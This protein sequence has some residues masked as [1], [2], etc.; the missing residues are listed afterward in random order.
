MLKVCETPNEGIICKVFLTEAQIE[1]AKLVVCGQVYGEAVDQFATL[2]EKLQ[3]HGPRLIKLNNPQPDQPCVC[4]FKD[5]EQWYRAKTVRKLAS[6]EW[7]VKFI[8]YG[9]SEKMNTDEL[10]VLP[11][12]LAALPQQALTMFLADWINPVGTA[13]V[14][15][16]VVS[17]LI[18]N[19]LVYTDVTVKVIEVLSPGKVKVKCSEIETV[20]CE[21]GYAKTGLCYPFS[22]FSVGSQFKAYTSHILDDG[23][24]YLQELQSATQLDELMDEMSHY[25]A[26][27]ESKIPLTE[28]NLIPGTI[29]AAVYSQDQGIYRAQILDVDGESST[30][31]YI[32]YGDSE[33]QE[34]VNMFVLPKQFCVLEYQAIA[35]SL[36]EVAIS[37]DLCSPKLKKVLTKCTA[38][39]ILDITVIDHKF[40]S[41]VQFEVKALCDDTNICI[42]LCNEDLAVAKP[43]TI[44]NAVEDSVKLCDPEICLGKPYKMVITH[45]D[46]DG[47]VYLMDVDSTASLDL[48]MNEIA[49]YCSSSDAEDVVYITAGMPCCALYD[50]DMMWYRAKVSKVDGDNITV[51]YVDYGNTAVTTASSLKK[52]QREHA[53][54]PCQAVQGSLSTCMTKDRIETL[55]ELTDEEVEVEFT[56]EQPGNKYA[57]NIVHHEKHLFCDALTDSNTQQDVYKDEM[58]KFKKYDLQVGSP[59]VITVSHALPSVAG[60]DQSSSLENLYSPCVSLGTFVKV[61]VCFIEDP[62]CLWVQQ[63]CNKKKLFTLMYSMN[64][65]YSLFAK[66]QGCLDET[67]T[68]K[69]CCIKLCHVDNVEDW[70]R[71]RILCSYGNTVEIKLIDFGNDIS[72]NRDEVKVLAPQFFEPKA[73]ALR[74]QINNIQPLKQRWA[75][76]TL[77]KL[78]DLVLRHGVTTMGRFIKRQNLTYHIDL[79]VEK[80]DQKL[81]VAQMLCDG[82]HASRLQPVTDVQ[83]QN[84]PA[85]PVQKQLDENGTKQVPKLF[86]QSP[87]MAMV[88]AELQV[89]ACTSKSPDEF[90]LQIVDQAYRQRYIRLFRKLYNFY[91]NKESVAGL[92]SEIYVGKPCAVFDKKTGDWCRAAILTFNELDN[93]T[94]CLV[95]IGR[96][97]FAAVADLYEISVEL[98]SAEPPA[99][100][101]CTLQG[102]VYPT[103]GE[104]SDDAVELFQGFFRQ[105]TQ[106]LVCTI[107]G[108]LGDTIGVAFM[109]SLKTPSTNIAVE[110]IKRGFCQQIPVIGTLAPPLWLKSY[111]YTNLD[112]TRGKEDVFHITHVENSKLFY[113]QL[114]RNFA[115]FDQMMDKLQDH[116][117][118]DNSP[119]MSVEEITQESMCFAK[120]QSEQWCR[121]HFV[122]T[123]PDGNVQVLFVDYGNVGSVC[124]GEIKRHSGNL[125]YQVPIMA[126]PC[127]LSDTVHVQTNSEH[128]QQI[129][130]SMK[131]KILEKLFTGIVTGCTN[132]KLHLDLFEKGKRINDEIVGNLLQLQ[133]HPVKTSSSSSL[134]TDEDIIGSR[135]HAEL[136]DAFFLRVGS[137]EPVLVTNC[138]NPRHFYLQLC[139]LKM[140][141][142]QCKEAVDGFYTAVRNSDYPVFELNPGNTVCAWHEK[143]TTW[144]RATVLSVAHPTD[145][146]VDVLYVDTGDYSKVDKN[147][148]VKQLVEEMLKWPKMSVSSSLAGIQPK[149]LTKWS[150]DA[151]ALFN[152]ATENGSLCAKFLHKDDSG[153]W[154]IKLYSDDVDI[155]HKLV[156]N[157]FASWNEE[158]CR[159]FDIHPVSLALKSTYLMPGKTDEVYISHVDS[160]EIIFVQKAETYKNL[161]KMM[162]DI[163][164]G[165]EKFEKLYKIPNAGSICLAK[166]E[167]D[168]LLYRARVAERILS[169]YIE[170][171]IL[172]VQ[173]VDYGNAASLSVDKV[174]QCPAKYLKEPEFAVRCKVLNVPSGLEQN[175]V[176]CK[177][178]DLST[179]EDITILCS[180]NCLDSTENCHKVNLKVKRMDETPLSLPGFWMGNAKSDAKPS[181]NN[182]LPCYKEMENLEGLSSKQVYISHVVNPGDV[183]C[184]LSEHCDQLEVLSNNISAYFA[185]HADDANDKIS[186][187]E[188]ISAG[189]SC[190]AKFSSDES[191]YRAVVIRILDDM[192]LVRFVDFG[193]EETVALSDIRHSKVSFCLYPIQ[194]IHCNLISVPS[195]EGKWSKEQ[196]NA[197]DR[198]VAALELT[199]TFHSF[200]EE[201]K[202]YQV[203]LRL[204][205]GTLLNN[206]YADQS[207]QDN[208]TSPN[209][210]HLNKNTK[211][212]TEPEANGIASEE[213]VM[214]NCLNSEN[215]LI[216]RLEIEPGC[217]ESAYIC[218]AEDPGNFYTQLAN[219]EETL[220]SIQRCVNAD[221]SEDVV[222]D[223]VLD[224]YC[225]A[226]S[227][228]DGQF[229][230][231]KI[232]DVYQPEATVFFIDYGNRASV[233]W[234]NVKPISAKTLEFSAQAIPCYLAN[235]P[236]Y[237]SEAAIKRAIDLFLSTTL[238]NKITVTFLELKPNGR[239]RVNIQIDD[240]GL[241]QQLQ[242]VEEA[243]INEVT[244]KPGVIQVA[245]E[246]NEVD[247]PGC[248][249]SD[250]SSNLEDN[251]SSVLE[252]G[253][254]SEADKPSSPHLSPISSS[255]TVSRKSRFDVCN[256]HDKQ[257]P[258]REFCD[259]EIQKGIIILA[260]STAHFYIRLDSDP[261]IKTLMEDIQ[262]PAE[263]DN[264]K[265]LCIAKLKPEENWQRAEVENKSDGTKTLFFVDTGKVMNSKRFLVATIP[266]NLVNIP[267][268]AICCSLLDTDILNGDEHFA[269]DVVG[270]NVLI[271]FR[272][273]ET[274]YV[275]NFTIPKW[276]VELL[277]LT[278]VPRHNPN[279]KTEKSDTEPGGFDPCAV[280][281]PLLPDI[282]I[283]GVDGVKKPQN[284]T[285]DF[286]AVEGNHSSVHA[287]LLQLK[288]MIVQEAPNSKLLEQTEHILTKTANSSEQP[289][290]PSTIGADGDKSFATTEA[291]E[292]HKRPS[293]PLKDAIESPCKKPRLDQNVLVSPNT[294]D[295][296]FSN[297]WLTVSQLLPKAPICEGDVHE[298]FVS[299][300]NTIQSFYVQ[301]YFLIA[302]REP[303]SIIKPAE[304]AEVSM[305]C[306]FKKDNQDE[307]DRCVVL[308]IGCDWFTVGMI[309]S[310]E[311]IEVEN[312]QLFTMPDEY[313]SY[314]PLAIHCSLSLE[315]H[316]D[317][318]S[319]DSLKLFKSLTEGEKNLR[320]EFI[321]PPSDNSTKWTVKLTIDSSDVSELLVNTLSTKPNQPTDENVCPAKV[322]KPARISGGPLLDIGPTFRSLASVSLPSISEEDVESVKGNTYIINPLPVPMS[323]ESSL[324]VIS[325]SVFVSENEASEM[326]PSPEIPKQISWNIY[327]SSSEKTPNEIDPLS[328]SQ[329]A[330]FP[331]T[332]DK[333]AGKD[334]EQPVLCLETEIDQLVRELVNSSLT[335]NEKFSVFEEPEK[336]SPILTAPVPLGNS[337]VA[338]N[339]EDDE[340]EDKNVQADNSQMI[341]D[342]DF[343]KIA[344]N[345]VQQVCN[346]AVAI[347]GETCSCAS[348]DILKSTTQSENTT[349]PNWKTL[350]NDSNENDVSN[351][352]AESANKE[353]DS[354]EEKCDIDVEFNTSEK[355]TSEK[356]KEDSEEVFLN[357]EQITSSENL[358]AEL[359]P[360]NSVVDSNIAQE[361][362]K[363]EDTEETNDETGLVVEIALNLSELTDSKCE[364][365]DSHLYEEN[366]SSC[367][368]VLVEEGPD[369]TPNPVSQISLDLDLETRLPSF[370]T[371]FQGEDVNTE[372]PKVEVEVNEGDVEFPEIVVSECKDDIST[373]TTDIEANEENAVQ[374]AISVAGKITEDVIKDAIQESFSPDAIKDQ[375]LS[376]PKHS[377]ASQEPEETSIYSTPLSEYNDGDRDRDTH[378]VTLTHGCDDNS[379]TRSPQDD[380]LFVSAREDSDKS[381]IFV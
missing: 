89:N 279:L 77:R 132:G 232:I 343:M 324:S 7:V 176:I 283:T 44:K 90:F 223:V 122:S 123:L 206:E 310:G 333:E 111:I 46:D 70:Y 115:V 332:E 217:V 255:T 58:M 364:S 192:V 114:E 271:T 51:K 315:N 135:L 198:R 143:T 137:K 16:P 349:N 286:Q 189:S 3:A 91:S 344:E 179:S 53:K 221:A 359:K 104:W 9:N 233:K 201:E 61:N 141:L 127:C 278:Q 11:E 39:G 57:V 298:G 285:N 194:A 246:S 362:A 30:V 336:Q 251:A 293:S 353:A 41:T 92:S 284:Q 250:T 318:S 220:E 274:Y 148:H 265:G 133:A 369:L 157:G 314:P 163:N 300:V 158:E 145:E 13:G 156:E 205:D 22:K 281:T 139:R 327:H 78:K 20:L 379:D 331:S 268:S 366:K 280:S 248:Q 24:L 226:Q 240:H 249:S 229:Y 238:D 261:S 316:L 216:N 381:Q 27:Q 363:K 105:N 188:A 228:E 309:D 88:G 303:C 59:E 177:L 311:I 144:C 183:Y 130:S 113:C 66:D 215:D 376:T 227:P 367:I 373:K 15:T 244:T 68:D 171:A 357:Q 38:N 335:P 152:S 273:V 120:F 191:W 210:S 140:D 306:L 49:A 56:K 62:D 239:W 370:V 125:F 247:A 375:F 12:K 174:Y 103:G 172:F 182:D 299:H 260:S 19:S 74:C 99:A 6:G 337:L 85:S 197:F 31:R 352:T 29:M 2:T 136:S 203:M 34:R 116:C 256:E 340:D 35:C 262:Y 63:D 290:H 322:V 360:E 259:G 234:S 164:K 212:Q 289:I 18:L 236:V 23:T 313:K 8:D 109:C 264:I 149:P 321:N 307:Y 45:V 95:D 371:A 231:G 32:D 263:G 358:K 83:L 55:K 355:M 36:Q 181:V 342:V 162:A 94:L 319:D 341:E 218:F 317:E 108:C 93:V 98:V 213:K 219:C 253:L 84:S 54:L 257:L 270:Q 168:G 377:G 110:L 380:L 165:N 124:W 40:D 117:L 235:L 302:D 170:E 334:E 288:N 151:I 69:L 372:A 82:G 14:W 17:S 266:D 175:E 242:F 320:V 292:D 207:E 167:V 121:A 128:S 75:K 1:D 42:F 329:D 5:D 76:A 196:I 33:Q 354:S 193:N 186:L 245:T 347:V 26:T 275:S 21:S 142:H 277:L 118:H 338:S 81:D 378:D 241:S 64:T 102:T 97:T 258:K 185:E 361:V 180:T 67:R 50:V 312:Q 348:I 225:V 43:E 208:K 178:G 153:T 209:E 155:A 169:N 25:F 190:V 146:F 150:P 282:L 269:G 305:L 147:M 287:L 301:P 134:D 272:A 237:S 71:G 87:G 96:I 195:S 131:E 199:A 214:T 374:E 267:A 351:Q 308:H 211:L 100:L 101:R 187:L 294:R 119:L 243:N 368:T 326:D 345:I 222:S 365:N 204:P 79:V 4:M 160:H 339:S 296:L 80:D 37:P 328:H 276:R 356:L 154:M 173:F 28:N 224:S 48:L 184:Q 65:Y 86:Y 106:E 350:E 346:K 323:S 72:V 73:Q 129:C 304:S 230:R 138:L 161:E 200:N 252:S 112:V 166:Y 295:Q 159:A 297:E 107:H 291:Q 52:L 60:T 254:D 10:H 325:D 202:I 47:K 126:L 330:K